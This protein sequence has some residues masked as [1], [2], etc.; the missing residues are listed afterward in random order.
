MKYK[1]AYLLSAAA[2]AASA[3]PVSAA[4]LLFTLSGSRNATFQLDSNP[5]PDFFNTQF[6]G[7]S[8]ASSQIRFDNIAGTFNGAPG[9]ASI[10]FGTNLFAALNINGTPLG[11][12]QFAGPAL[13][14]GT[15][16]SPVFSTGTYAL[17]S[18]VSGAS[19]LTISDVGAVPEPATWA[20]M[21]TGFGLTGGA[22][23]RRRSKPAAC[24]A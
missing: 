16:A 6:A 24:Y 20:M 14:T 3:M 17:T 11:F 4:T 12:T 5:A 7:T 1:I 19:T 18:I 22:M 9:V 13:F 21:I 23:R 2:F 10:G 8:L 15:A